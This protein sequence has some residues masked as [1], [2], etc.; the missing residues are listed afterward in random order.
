MKPLIIWEK[1]IDPFGQDMDEAKWTDY[2][3]DISDLDGSDD[4][5]SE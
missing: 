5:E 2:N 1:W 4:P 3:N